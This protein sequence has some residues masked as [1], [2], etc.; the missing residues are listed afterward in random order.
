MRSRAAIAVDLDGMLLDDEGRLSDRNRRALAAARDHGIAVVAATTRPPRAVETVDGLL[1]HFDAALCLNGAVDYD[2]GTRR[3][4]DVQVIAV[5]RALLLWESLSAR[6]PR[7]S[8]A[9]ETGRATI[10]QTRHF[11][12]L[13]FAG[14]G[15]TFVD[16]PEDV[17]ALA[18]PITVFS[19]SDRDAGPDALREAASAVDLSGPAMWSWGSFPLLDFNLAG[20]DKGRALRAWCSERGVGPESVA[21]FGDMPAAASMLTWAGQSYAMANAQPEAVAAAAHRTAS[22]IDDGVALAV[23]QLLGLGPQHIHSMSKSQ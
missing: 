6:L 20:I 13:D 9:V 16:G 14:G 23:E 5:E 10:S 3:V 4:G 21:V 2:T 15:W 19:V 8:C 7:A 11:A 22:N 12:E 1:D 18:D 17:F